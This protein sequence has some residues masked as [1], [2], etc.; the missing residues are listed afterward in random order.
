MAVQYRD[1]DVAAGIFT[2]AIAMIFFP[3]RDFKF[4]KVFRLIY[5]INFFPYSRGIFPCGYR[6]RTYYREIIVAI[7]ISFAY[8][9]F[10][11]HYS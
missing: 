5:H 9:D 2:L 8:S 3:Y 10:S 11:T 7:G 6:T 4:K 1:F